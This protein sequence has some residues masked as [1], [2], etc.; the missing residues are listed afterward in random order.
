MLAFLL[1]AGL[2]FVTLSPINLRPISPL[3]TQLE[4]AL[5]LAAVGFAFAIAY[6]KRIVLVALLVLGST[7][8]L[9]LLQL[10][11]PSRHGRLVD[12]IVKLIGAGF[13]MSLGWA[14]A[15]FW[16]SHHTDRI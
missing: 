10:V 8:L 1:L 6:P 4:R 16:P 14:V 9:E 12:L 5:A 13:G 7:V 3:P 15:R 11:S 2:V